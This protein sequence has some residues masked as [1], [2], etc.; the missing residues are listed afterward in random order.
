MTLQER[1]RQTL[2]HPQRLFELGP[3]QSSHRVATRAGISVF[4]P[5]LLLWLTGHLDLSLYAV[6]GAFASLYGR[7]EAHL[8]RLPMQALAGC[9]LVLSVIAGTAIAISP[10]RAWLIVP[11][12]ALWAGAVG[13]IVD[14]VRAHPPG[15]MFPVFAICACASVPSSTDG[16][17]IA[18]LVAS[19]SASFA[20]LVGV[21][22]V[23]WHHRSAK[24]LAMAR[25]QSHGEPWPNLSVLLGQ[26]E[27]RH[28]LF[29][30]MAAPAVA[31]LAAT[32]LG[33]GRP[34]W[35]MVTAVIPMAAATTPERI[36]R[37][38]HR[39]VGTLLGLALAAGLL[40]V[41]SSGLAAL[42]LITALQIGAELLVGVNYSLALIFITPLALSMVQLARYSP[43]G[44]LLVDR[45]IET[46]LGIAV[47][48][49]ATLATHEQSTSAELD[50]A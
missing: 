48:I 38:L 31:G 20:I 19:A 47:A 24:S 12:G 9:I 23:L 4:V 44:V 34:Y 42:T 41:H 2:P 32:A 21:A 14:G 26:V 30:Y 1:L 33:L 35:A 16:V 8:S 5:L 25:S 15:P 40:A 36:L 6:F 10:E 46:I 3:F 37:A 50:L 43:P 18:A 39:L 29:R 49:V 27:L 17:A 22:G 45:G 7:N 28:H 13:L 11:L